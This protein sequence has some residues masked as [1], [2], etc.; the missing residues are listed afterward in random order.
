MGLVVPLVDAVAMQARICE[1]SAV[2]E[3]ILKIGALRD[4]VPDVLEH[5]FH[6]FAQGTVAEHAQLVIEE[7]PVETKCNACGCHFFPTL[8][9]KAALE[10][11]ACG[12]SDYR[13]V[14]GREFSLE[15]I[16]IEQ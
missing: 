1:A 8:P 14:A 4:V 5:C 7:V 2:T 16:S 12:S 15:S 13:L 10:C 9:V 11:P 6:H 3:V